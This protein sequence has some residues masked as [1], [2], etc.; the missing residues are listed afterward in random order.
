MGAA[1]ERKTVC[2][3]E[4]KTLSAP[5]GAPLPK[6]EVAGVVQNRYRAKRYANRSL[7]RNLRCPLQKRYR[8]AI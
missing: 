4:A 7:E 3:Y 8:A 1:V 6:G 2:P 5:C